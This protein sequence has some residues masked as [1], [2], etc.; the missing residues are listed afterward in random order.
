MTRAFGF[1]A[2]LA[3]C[4]ALGVAGAGPLTAQQVT[5]RLHRHYVKVF[6]DLSLTKERTA[7]VL[8]NGKRVKKRIPPQLGFSR[9]PMVGD[10]PIGVP[11][12]KADRALLASGDRFFLHAFGFGADGATL[13]AKNLRPKRIIAST[14]GRP[15]S[16]PPSQE[17]ATKFI[18]ER[19][20]AVLA[21]KPAAGQLGVWRVEAKRVTLGNPACLKCHDT[22]K[23]GDPVAAIVYFSAPRP[24][25]G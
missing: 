3:A 8:E 16:A 17:Q 20:D 5:D 1:A 21:G 10:H 18:M 15:S 12:A 9:I 25:K 2:V 14:V 24:A 22:S 19:L 13:T 4:A 7:F 11:L 23:V 6:H